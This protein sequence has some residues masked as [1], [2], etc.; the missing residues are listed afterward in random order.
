MG[1]SQSTE[2]VVVAETEPSRPSTPVA[3][4][5]ADYK[6]L[7]EIVGAGTTRIFVVTPKDNTSEYFVLQIIN[8]AVVDEERRD[9][10][11]NELWMSKNIQHPNSTSSVARTSPLTLDLACSTPSPRYL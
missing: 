2:A 1:C 6:V 10:L 7:K 5:L 11:R 3:P 4:Y 9:S 8:L